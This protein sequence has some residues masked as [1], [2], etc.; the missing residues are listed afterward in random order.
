MILYACR[1]LKIQETLSSNL[2]DKIRWS[3][4]LKEKLAHEASATTGCWRGPNVRSF[5]LHAGRLFPNFNPDLQC[6]M[7]K[8]KI[9][10]MTCDAKSHISVFLL[11]FFPFKPSGRGSHQC[12]VWGGLDVSILTL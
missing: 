2:S 11:Y 3:T 9:F 6:T 10:S 8:P 7:G 12:R 4:N 5:T 1:L